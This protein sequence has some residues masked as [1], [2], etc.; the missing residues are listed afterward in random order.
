VVDERLDRFRQEYGWKPGPH[1]ILEVDDWTKRLSTAFEIDPKGSI[2]Q[3]RDLTKQERHFIAN[4]RAMCVASCL[5]FLT[6]YYWIKAK[7]RILRFTFRQGQW[8]L[9]QMLCELDRMGVSKMLQILKARQLGISTLAE[10]IGRWASM[11]IP[12]VAAQIGSSD[13]QKTQI[14]LS[15]I[16]LAS[17]M[18]PPW[19][20]PTETRS[21]TKSD[22]GIMEYDKIGS[23]IMI[24]HG[25]MRGGMGQGATPTFVHLSEVSQFTN[26]VQQ[27]DEGLFKALHEGPELIVLLEATGDPSHKSAWWWK[28]QWITNRDNYWSGRAKFLPVFLPWHTTPELY[29]GTDWLHKF[30]MPADF[31]PHEDTVAHVRR[32]EAYVRNTKMLAKILG[33]DWTMPVEQQW[34]WQFNY[35]DHKRRRVEKSWFR[36]MPSDD[37]EALMGERDKIV[38]EET[39]EVMDSSKRLVADTPAYMV[40]G[41]GITEKYE[42]DESLVWYG[43]D[44]PPRLKCHW[45]TKGDQRLEWMF[46]PL[47]PT[48]YHG[49]T[50]KERRAIE[51]T[52]DPLGKCL[53]YKEPEEGYDYALGWDCGTGVGGDR[54]SIVMNRKGLNDGEPDE[55][56]AEFASDDVALQDICWWACALSALYSK[57][58]KEKPHPKMCIEMKRKYGDGPYHE[59]KLAG[60]R[61]WHEWGWGFDRKTWR[62][63]PKG[64]HGRIGWFTNEWSR[65]LLLSRFFGAVENGW[66]TVR[67]KWLAQEIA[68]MEQKVTDSG[69]TRADHEAGKHDDRVFAAAMSYFTLHQCDVMASRMKMRYDQPQGEDLVIEHGPAVGMQTVLSGRTLWG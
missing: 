18:L 48:I 58:M 19:L 28:E 52:F 22:R 46:V 51:M 41:D 69:K 13:G 25:A 6:R 20:P 31:R 68:E 53:I 9:W 27:L 63:R 55:Q 43:D 4:E 45:K 67:S 3:T 8:V 11:F 59:A 37:Y 1:S 7:N 61:R 33:K 35:D 64:E 12:G 60:F 40:V 15:M 21:K 65:P 5:Y 56:V 47:R 23:M 57:Y 29:P 36:Q 10:G 17:E 49:M 62:E 16:L 24:Q 2:Y 34:F 30:P 50:D 32:A 39:V 44:S 54:S 26:P 42:P 38:G 66:Y 14:M